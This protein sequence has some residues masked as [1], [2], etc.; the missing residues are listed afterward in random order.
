MPLGCFSPSPIHQAVAHSSFTLSGSKLPGKSTRQDLRRFP[1]AISSWRLVSL[2]SPRRHHPSK[3]LCASAPLRE[4]SPGPEFSAAPL[5]CVSPSP[6]HHPRQAPLQ[7]IP[8]HSLTP[9]SH[10][11]SGFHPT[12]PAGFA[13]PGYSRSARHGHKS[14]S[15]S[16]PRAPATLA[17]SGC[18]HPPPANASQRNAGTHAS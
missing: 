2:F 13:P 15:S 6:S 1:L 3:N 17:A 10:I 5:L 11:P 16:H 9:P 14:P 4:T 8:N 18:P 12:H 7:T